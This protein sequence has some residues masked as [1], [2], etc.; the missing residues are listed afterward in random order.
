MHRIILNADVGE[1]AGF[2]AQIM[3]Y[4]SWCSIACG[5]HVGDE[6]MIQKTVDLALANNV[7][8]GAHPSYPDRENFGRVVLEM[9]S[10]DLADS[11]STQILAVKEKVEESGGKLHHVKPHGALYNYAMQNENVA[12]IIIECVKNIDKSLQL[13]VLKNSVFSYLCKGELEL[14][15]EAFADR[16]YR[17]DLTLVPRVEEGAVLTDPKQVFEQVLQMV[18]EQKVKTKNGEVV[19]VF[20]DTICIHGDTPKSS[21]ILA[22]IYKELSVRNFVLKNGL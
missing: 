12:N 15:Y 7:K 13:I 10:Q 1:G 6:K 20:F 18:S 3:P 19:P 16:A 9:S 2:D 22:Y 14:K 21:E 8:I 11:I 5:A 4:I 17:K